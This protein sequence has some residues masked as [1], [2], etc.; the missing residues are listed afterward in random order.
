MYSARC[1]EG[2]PCIDPA[3]IVEREDEQIDNNT[4]VQALSMTLTNRD[5][6]EDPRLLDEEILTRPGG[7]FYVLLYRSSEMWWG[8]L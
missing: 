3:P 2:T 7:C 4:P 8:S 5:F 1:G 6:L